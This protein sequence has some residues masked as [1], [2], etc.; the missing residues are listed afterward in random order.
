MLIGPWSECVLDLYLPVLVQLVVPQDDSTV[1]PSSGQQRPAPH[2]THAENSFLMSFDE[3][4]IRP[5]LE[6]CT[7]THTHYKTDQ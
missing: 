2:V 6:R 7:H 5:H 3:S 1:L 4:Q